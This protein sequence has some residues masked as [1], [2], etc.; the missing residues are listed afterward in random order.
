MKYKFLKILYSICIVV[1]FVVV[2][3]IFTVKETETVFVVQFG[4]VMRVVDQSGLH[5]RVP[6][7]QDIV[8]F[9]KR[10]NQVDSPARE[11]ISLDQKRLIVDAYTKY[12][13]I[14]PQAFF[15]TLKDEYGAN[16]RITSILDSSMR[17]VVAS[18]PLTAFLTAER[19]SIMERVKDLLIKQTASFGIKIIDVRIIRGD[20]P[21]ENSES[22]FLRMK[23]AREREAGEL[24][25]QGSEEAI[26]IR[27]EADKMY[28]QTLAIAK[29]KAEQIMGKADGEAIKIYASVAKM[30]PSFFKFYL[31]M[32]AY[33][34]SMSDGKKTIVL[35]TKSEFLKDLIGTT[36]SPTQTEN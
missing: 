30:D 6:F 17:Q 36:E 1:I 3:S 25:A 10:I 12:K 34:D 23:T 14:N 31:S 15:E 29:M 8:S 32:N 33:R 18:Y 16:S 11:V 9:D 22:I 13:M 4:K 35:G 7:I 19:Q 2:M 26:K 28:R 20:L 27:S 5:F 21:T 24:R